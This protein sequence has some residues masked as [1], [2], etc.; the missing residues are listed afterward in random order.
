MSPYEYE[1]TLMN[2]KNFDLALLV[3][4]L[5]HPA[6]GLLKVAAR[7]WTNEGTGPL[8]TIGAAVEVA[9]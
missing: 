7:R 1:R 8:S 9:L 5:A 2:R 6:F 3:V 4:L